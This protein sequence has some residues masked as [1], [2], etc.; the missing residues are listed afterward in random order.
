MLLADYSVEVG[1]PVISVC[2]LV[3]GT[4][5]LLRRYWDGIETKQP[6]SSFSFPIN[7]DC[8]EWRFHFGWKQPAQLRIA[9][10]RKQLDIV[11]QHFEPA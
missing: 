8:R 11:L 7:P 9:I 5:R 10:A 1:S 2:Q 6:G 4:M 3:V